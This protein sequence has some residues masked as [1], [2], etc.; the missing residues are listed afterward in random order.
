MYYILKLNE[1]TIMT[2]NSN[3]AVELVADGYILLLSD[4]NYEYVRNYYRLV[5]DS[6]TK[7]VL[8]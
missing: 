7:E 5:K 2:S 3:L 1:V 8:L 4:S 6:S